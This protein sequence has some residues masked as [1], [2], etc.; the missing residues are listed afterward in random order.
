MEAD[1][2]DLLDDQNK[3]MLKMLEIVSESQQWYS[4][5]ELSQRLNVVERTVQRYIHQLEDTLDEYNEVKDSYIKLTYEKYNGV[6][7]ESETGSN[8]L[9]FKN[10][11]LENDETIQ[12]L[13]KILFEEF[14]SVNKYA[15]SYFVSENAIRKSLKKIKGFLNLYGL[16]LSR[17]SFQIEGEEKKI[18]I[19]GYII[20][21]VTF[22][23]VTWPFDSIDQLKAYNAVDSFSQ[24][25]GIKFSDVHR[26][27][28]A[29]MMAVNFIRLRKNHVIELEP[30][31]KDY[32]NVPAL[33]AT[34][35]P[36][37]T[38][39]DNYNIYVESELVFYALLLQMKIKIYE[40]EDLK[41]RIFD[42]HQKKQSDIYQTTTLFVTR[43]HDTLV[44][45]PAEIKERFFI[46]SFYAHLF[47]RVFNQLKVDIDGH[48]VINES[49]YDYP[50]LK[51]NLTFFIQSLHKES[52]QSIF[53]EKDFLLQKY[54]LLF[55]SVTPLNYYEPPI[56]LFL[57][58]DLP[59]FVKESIITKITDRF[60]HDFNI[61]FLTHQLL[62]ESDIVL[63]NIPN[64]IEEQQRFSYKVHL[65]DFPIKS[66]DF[67]EIEKKLKIVAKMKSQVFI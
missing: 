7:L 16:S 15:M 60:K 24:S 5:H 63:T 51:E 6:L 13:K 21:W 38:F 1:I 55:S 19:I 4:V 62:H 23:G 48:S 44:P 64:I 12:I 66:S 59:F 65:F 31:W 61:S 25:V 35:P 22:K 37:K 9:N 50:I 2:L 43:F 14:Y 26:K 53:L 20:G 47:C 41:Q 30:H 29:Y 11:I 33:L 42:F 28:M 40:S 17:S 58:T 32:V 49:D 67:Q 36:A 52:N 57:D 8:Y 45:I 3:I 56:R 34:L 18:R 46:T 54:L 10:H 27:Q 39:V